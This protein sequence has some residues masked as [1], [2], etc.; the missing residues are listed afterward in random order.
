MPFNIDY[1]RRKKFR[2]EKLEIVIVRKYEKAMVEVIRGI[3]SAFADPVTKFQN[4]D[5]LA[6]S[7]QY[8]E[9]VSAL[10]KDFPQ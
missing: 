7:K 4:V 6:L 8:N 3:I 5:F 10:V 2:S 9:E 1:L